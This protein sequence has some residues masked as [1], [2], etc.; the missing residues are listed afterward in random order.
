MLIWSHLISAAVN[1]KALWPRVLQ[2][3]CRSGDD[4]Q[5]TTTQRPSTVPEFLPNCALEGKVFLFPANGH[6]ATH[7]ESSA[8]QFDD[9]PRDVR[10]MQAF[11]RIHLHLHLRPTASM[12]GSGSRHRTHPP[13]LIKP[14]AKVKA[15][16]HL[17]TGAGGVAKT[18]PAA[19]H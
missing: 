16:G 14:K 15:K 8:R 9:G 4:P 19:G 3:T 5:N 1:F 13:Q 17:T 11:L 12:S 6:I 10:Q 2:R 18:S 7:C